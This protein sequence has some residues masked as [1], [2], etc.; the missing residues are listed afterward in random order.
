[1][2]K[3]ILPLCLILIIACG[4]DRLAVSDSSP[5]ID[6]STQ[7]NTSQFANAKEKLISMG[8]NVP[9]ESHKQEFVGSLDIPIEIKDRFFEILGAITRVLGS[10]PNY[11]YFAF[12]RNGT[13]ADAKPVFDRLSEINVLQD[14]FT[15]AELTKHSC[16][17]G[18][19]AGE[20]R[21]VTTEPYSVCVQNL[22]HIQNP[23]NHPPQ[24]LKEHP[25]RTLGR[26]V[27]N[28][29]HEYFHHY[30]RVHALDR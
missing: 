12:N 20:A 24:E 7:T 14:K 19:N 1:M 5:Q 11:V 22:A 21:T 23:F 13:E 2:K 28:Y 18:S 4:G 29:A 3:I 6:S 10:Y 27:L 25:E 30:Q 16:L 17:G 15:I 9:S 8:F 26:L